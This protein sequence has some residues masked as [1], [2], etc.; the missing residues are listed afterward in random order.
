MGIGLLGIAHRTIRA[1]RSH[2]QTNRRPRK[3]F[4][5]SIK[6]LGDR[7]RVARLEKGLI[8]KELAKK[9]GI[10]TRHVI[11]WEQDKREPTQ[12]QR[13][14]LADILAISAT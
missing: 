14:Q 4:P 6:T 10:P 3:R 13:K 7:I 5:E 8:Q 1:S 2:I 12:A 9:L 11:R